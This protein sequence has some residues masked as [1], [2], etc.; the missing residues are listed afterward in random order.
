MLPVLPAASRPICALRAV[1]RSTTPRSTS[2]TVS[3]ICGSM[4]CRQ[5]SCANSIGWP[6]ESSTSTTA[7]AGQNF[8]CAG[9][10]AYAAA[11]ASGLTSLTP[12]VNDPPRS[13]GSVG[14]PLANC[15]TP[16]DSATA[17]GCSMPVRSASCT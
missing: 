10:V 6:L 17:G 11:M 3:A 8:P 16:S 4:A 1:P 13:S 7:L 2:V 15:L 5:S 14:S 9:K 12:R